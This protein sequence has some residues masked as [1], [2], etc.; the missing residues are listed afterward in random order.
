MPPCHGLIAPHSAAGA[1]VAQ[2]SIA[3][4]GTACARD[5]GLNFA[6]R[7]EARVQHTERI[8]PAERLLIIVEM[9]RLLSHRPVPVKAEPRQVFEDR[10]SVVVAASGRV[11]VLEPKQKAAPIAPRGTPSFEHRADVAE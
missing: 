5:L 9:L 10:R 3:M 2:S 1:R 6:P 11:D 8:Q 4:R 7:A